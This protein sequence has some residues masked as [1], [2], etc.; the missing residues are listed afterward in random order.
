[1]V[2]TAVYWDPAMMRYTLGG[3]HPMNPL[4]WE[5]AWQLSS[6][7][8]VLD[9]VSLIAPPPAGQAVLELVHSADYIEAVKQAGAG[10]GGQCGLGTDDNPIWPEIHTSAALIAGG[11]VAAAQAI[12][13]HECDRAVNIAGGLHHAMPNSAAGFCIYNDAALAIA[14]LLAAGLEKVAYLDVDVHHGDGVQTAFWH[15]DRVLTISVHESPLTLW[16]GTGWPTEVGAGAARGTAVNIPIPAGS[17]DAA[18][19]RAFHAVVPGVLSAFGP[20]VLVSQHGA[21]AHRDD[22]LANLSLTVD[23]QLAAAQA[24]RDLANRHTG[25][26]W[27]A[28]GGGG[29]E[30]TGVVPRAY[31]HLLATALDRDIDPATCLPES[32]RRTAGAI[33]AAAGFP[34]PGPQS[35]TDLDDGGP[36]AVRCWDGTHEMLVD[37][38]ID[39]VRRLIYPLHG[40]DPH[41]PRD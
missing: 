16:P 11:S 30:Y 33:R 23:G 32:W 14:A 38:A 36:L 26:K 28:L 4:R 10:R 37:V 19:L 39:Q 40:L 9:G 21:D 15:D 20:Q 34:G 5:L 29:Y 31:T 25:G 17:D 13:A 24:C 18:W 7:L 2:R 1:M 27:L 8:G 3:A 22:P 35:M 6:Q 12:A 41:D